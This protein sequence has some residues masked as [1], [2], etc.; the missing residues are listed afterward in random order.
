[1]QFAVASVQAAIEDRRNWWTSEL[2]VNVV[3]SLED[4]KLVSL[5][6]V[7]MFGSKTRVSKKQRLSGQLN[8]HWLPP[9]FDSD[10]PLLRRGDL[11]RHFSVPALRSGFSLCI[12][13]YQKNVLSFF[14]ERG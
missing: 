8:C 10:E 9:N 2:I 13:H 1:M 5:N 12:R 14:C 4:D 11:L 6:L 3:V 7:S